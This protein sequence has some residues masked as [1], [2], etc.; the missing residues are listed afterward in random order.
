[1]P[2]K[3]ELSEEEKMQ[4]FRDMMRKIGK[5]GGEKK[6]P[7]KARDPEKMRE[8]QRKSVEARKRKREAGED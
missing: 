6:G 4:V 2:R 3:K 5:K 7:T 1:M 8:A